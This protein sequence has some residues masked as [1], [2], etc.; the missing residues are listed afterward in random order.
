VYNHI[1]PVINAHIL[2]EQAGLRPTRNCYDPVLSLVTYIKGG[3]EKGNK[4][5]ATFND[6]T[7]AYDLVWRTGLL[8]KFFSDSMQNP[9]QPSQQYS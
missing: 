6:L 2:T 4:I 8:L 7:V 9:L 5:A 1:L 3:F